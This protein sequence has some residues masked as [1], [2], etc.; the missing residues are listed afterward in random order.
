M[1]S[2]DGVASRWRVCVERHQDGR[3]FDFDAATT[4]KV[5]K[6]TEVE[7]AKRIDSPEMRKDAK[8]VDSCEMKKSAK[9]ISPQSC[10]GFQMDGKE[11]EFV[12]E[13]RLKKVRYEVG[14]QQR[15]MKKTVWHPGRQ[16]V[17]HHQTALRRETS[18]MGREQKAGAVSKVLVL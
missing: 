2:Y 18:P 6:E 1:G 17:S 10:Q 12:E 3:S 8:H 9:N 14:K 16:V 13:S 5:Y 11:R 7:V 15:K 4:E